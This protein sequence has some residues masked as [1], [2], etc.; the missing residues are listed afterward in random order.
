MLEAT[1][2]RLGSSLCSFS[3]L[4]QKTTQNTNHLNF[5]HLSGAGKRPAIKIIRV[6]NF[7]VN[8]QET[9]GDTASTVDKTSSLHSPLHKRV[10]WRNADVRARECTRN[11]STF[12]K[13]T[14]SVQKEVE[15]R[16]ERS[17][18]FLSGVSLHLT[19]KIRSLQRG[20]TERAGIL[21]FLLTRNLFSAMDLMTTVIRPPLVATHGKHISFG[22]LS[23]LK[24]SSIT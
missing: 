19:Q 5:C 21:C 17:P 9:R 6:R 20:H 14:S 18:I 7:Y 11:S 10:T 13:N 12:K 1:L 15:H 2:P 24:G 16:A 3:F 23:S 8:K 4:S 22:S